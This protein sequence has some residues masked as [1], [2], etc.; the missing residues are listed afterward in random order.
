[1]PVDA[2][3]DSTP[4][5][6]GSHGLASS[7]QCG[8]AALPTP[9]QRTYTLPSGRAVPLPVFLP[10]YQARGTL[11]RLLPEDNGLAIEGLIVNAY[12]LYKERSIRNLLL[13]G[14]KLTEFVGFDGFITT[15]SGAF[16]GFTRQLFL[17]NKEIVRFQDKIRSDVAAPLDLVTPPGD[18]RSVAEAKLATTNKRVREALDL[19]EYS[20][21]SGVQQGG[22]FMD[23]RLR[24]VEELTSMGVRYLALG[25]LVPFFNRNHDLGFV[26]SVIRQARDI[27]GPDMPIHV[28]GAGDPLELPFMVK[29]GATIFDSSSYAHYAKKGAYMT[30]YGALTEPSRLISGEY[31]CSCAACRQSAGGSEL[32]HDADR[33]SKHNLHTI[34]A[35]VAHVRAIWTRPE[36]FQRYLDKVL[37]IHQR[38]FPQSALQ[39]S[40]EKLLG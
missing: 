7:A 23:L 34:L 18:R 13:G 19:A 30:P 17:S 31:A 39:Q 27:A 26:G 21:I 28:Y 20:V 6:P 29:L 15:D 1:M 2:P 35:T 12:F 14:R 10:V 38:W 3:A 24:A 8:G 22:R 25:S 5:Y 32:F 40:L 9:P 4:S 37:D 33:L 36:I 16:Q 11:F